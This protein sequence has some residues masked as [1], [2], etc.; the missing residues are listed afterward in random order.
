M[1]PAR[2][3][4][5]GQLLATCERCGAP[6]CYRVG[7]GGAS[8]DLAG[9]A[10]FCHAHWQARHA[11]EAAEASKAPPAPVAARR[12]TDLFGRG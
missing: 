1:S 12:P 2:I 7:P 9:G 5:G 4:P 10:W 8:R 6:A 11:A 3:S